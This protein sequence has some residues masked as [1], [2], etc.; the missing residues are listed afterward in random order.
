LEAPHVQQ[1]S[2]HVV[3]LLGRYALANEDTAHGLDDHIRIPEGTSLS[4]RH[5]IQPSVQMVEWV[6]LYPGGKQL[7][8]KPEHFPL[9]IAKA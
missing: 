1:W 7:E 6:N 9:P 8:R 3:V 4:L 2:A 5:R